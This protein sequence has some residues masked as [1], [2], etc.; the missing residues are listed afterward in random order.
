MSTQ[1]HPT[2]C[3]ICSM[4][5]GIEVQTEGERITRVRPDQNHH[6]TKGYVCEKAQR[7]DA[8]QQGR[9]RLS[10]PM[11]RK[12]DGTYEAVD[13]DTAIREVAAGRR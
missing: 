9:D 1:W 4:N 10:S 2:A 12:A 7:M 8:Y 3:M 11:R 6:V 13:W 5:C